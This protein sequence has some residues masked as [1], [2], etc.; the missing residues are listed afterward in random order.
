MIR[1]SWCGARNYA[2]D[3]WCSKCHQHLD[4]GPRARGPRPR[5]RGW[6][7]LAPVAAALG[8][9][10]AL[11]LPVASWFNGALGTPAR[12]LPN[13]ALLAPA[14]RSSADALAADATPTDEVSAPAEPTPGEGSTPAPVPSVPRPALAPV[15]GDPAAAVARFY[16]AVTAHDFDGAAALWSATMQAQY[17]PAQYI[18]RRFAATQQI[19]LLAERVVATGAGVAV[20]YVDIVELSGG[21]TR[22]WIGT[23]Q[24]IDSPT[25]WLLNQ[26]DLAAAA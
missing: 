15:P 3:S 8:V 14:A 18:N 11:A 19:N 6:S 20:V 7:R 17:P 5:R 24:L 12:G 13:T 25:G 22:H 26:A 2:I 10:I 1:C 16:Q 23:W 21:Q 4:F 9:A